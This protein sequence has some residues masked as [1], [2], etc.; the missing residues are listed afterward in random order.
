MVYI[1]KQ[2]LKDN[3][4]PH[5]CLLGIFKPLHKG[6]SASFIEPSDITEVISREEFN[7]ICRRELEPI[8][9]SNNPYMRDNIL[10]TLYFGIQL[11]RMAYEHK[12]EE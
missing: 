12:R 6:N 2:S 3:F 8:M 1:T 9:R 10:P 7:S 5:M 4:V 11:V